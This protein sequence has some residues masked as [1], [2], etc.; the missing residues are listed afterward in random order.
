MGGGGSKP[1]PAQQQPLIINEPEPVRPVTEGIAISMAGECDTC[2]ILVDPNI[3]TSSVKLRREFGDITYTQC[4]KLAKDE[5]DLRN[6]R[7]SLQDFLARMSS[8]QYSRPVGDGSHCET[9][10]LSKEAQDKIKT[11]NDYF[12][13][14]IWNQTLFQGSR[15]RKVSQG[16]FSRDTKVRIVPSIPFKVVVNANVKGKPTRLDVNIA[17][18]MLYH[19]SPIRLENVQHDAVLSLN[20]PATTGAGG[21]VILIPLVASGSSTPSAEFMSRILGNMSNLLNPDPVTGQYPETDAPTGAGWTL[22]KLLPTDPETNTVTTG[23]FVWE[24]APEL[25]RYLSQDTAAIKRTSWRPRGSGGPMYIMTD[26]AMSMSGSDFSTLLRFPATPPDQA[27]HRILDGSLVYKCGQKPTEAPPTASGPTELGGGVTTGTMVTRERYTQ[28]K[29]CDPFFANYERNYGYSPESML[30]IVFNV[31]TFVAIG[32]GA[33]IALTLVG[34]LRSD[35]FFQSMS[36]GAGRVLIRVMKG[37]QEKVKSVGNIQNL[38]AS[39]NQGV[40][41]LTSAALAAAPAG[42]AAAQ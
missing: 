35:K 17:D 27:V 1:A 30:T 11:P 14:K 24:G 29:T 13:G 36:F 3:S 18:M 41:G 28:K 20:D 22:N 39:R 40:A 21:V 4:S 16:G 37:A 26:T 10:T 5:D 8:G 12:L 42:A 38:I 9:I 15:I 6:Q 25:E 2:S 31:L 34:D 32:I 33:W 23:F 19:P 7:I